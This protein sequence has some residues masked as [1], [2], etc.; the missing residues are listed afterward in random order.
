MTAS[1]IKLMKFLDNNTP[2][3]RFVTAKKRHRKLDVKIYFPS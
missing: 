2:L 3:K 1:M